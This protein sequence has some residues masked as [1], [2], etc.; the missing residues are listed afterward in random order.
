MTIAE[1]RRRAV[2]ETLA[3]IRAIEAADGVNRDT[4][5]RMK[6]CLLAL[7][8]K[9][10]LFPQADFPLPEPD[11]RNRGHLYRLSEDDDHRY[12]L[13][14]NAAL[15]GIDSPVHDHT[16]K[17]EIVTTGTGVSLMPD[18]LHSI[19]IHGSEPVLNFHAYGLAL[20]QLHGRQY[21]REKDD[22][23]LPFPASAH[24]REAR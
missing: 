3:E 16:T 8:A 24:I 23:W 19:H 1:A 20:E 13:Y 17:R 5:E 22:Q 11:S 12:A 18:D 9:H 14:A 15:S 10:E 2:N 7:A 4:L 21:Y 6:S